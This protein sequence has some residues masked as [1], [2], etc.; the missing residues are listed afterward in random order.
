MQRTGC[1]KQ[2]V[3]AVL[4]T[5]P[6]VA[7]LCLRGPRLRASCVWRAP[8]SCNRKQ[9]REIALGRRNVELGF[10]R[11]PADHGKTTGQIAGDAARAKL[12]RCTGERDS[13]EDY[14]DLARYP[15]HPLGSLANARLSPGRSGGGKRY[16]FSD[17]GRG[18]ALDLCERT[19]ALLDRKFP[20]GHVGYNPGFADL[21]PLH[22]PA[23]SAAGKVGWTLG[24]LAQTKIS[25]V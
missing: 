22:D 13:R 20:A 7:P 23:A 3:S 2:T 17:N 5:A 6:P 12:H 25:A 19:G 21:A 16:Q 9:R 24:Q 18:R 8:A 11:Q 1:S 14:G 15:A 10:E 4:G